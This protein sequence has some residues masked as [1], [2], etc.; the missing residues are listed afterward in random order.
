MNVVKLINRQAQVR[1]DA[2]A[3]MR[4]SRIIRYRQLAAAINNLATH[5]SAQGI[6]PGDRVGVAMGHMPVHMVFILA[7][8]RLRAVSLPVHALHSAETR[9]AIVDHFKPVTI[10]AGR[11]QDRVEGC[12]L[13]LADPSWMRK[14]A[15]AKL[16]P[17][18][19]DISSKDWHFHLSSGS[20]GLPKGVLRT[21]N[22]A[23]S[24]IL[25]QAS[26]VPSDASTRFLCVMDINTGASLMRA[27][28]YLTRGSA[29]IFPEAN[30]WEPVQ[31]I[32]AD[33]E[34][35][36]TFISPGHLSRW[37]RD[38]G[39]RRAPSPNLTYVV[40]GGG[41]LSNA[42]QQRATQQITSKI[43]TCYGSTETGLMA[44]QHPDDPE[45]E[46][47]SLGRVVPW[48]EVQVVDSG[49]QPL[50]P[51]EQGR[52]RFR[53]YGFATSY[54]ENPEA[55]ARFFRNSWFYPGDIG[56]VSARGSLFVESR[57]DDMLNVRGL[58][59]TPGESEGVLAAHPAV[60]EAATFRAR[61]AAG[62]EFLV[63]AVV[64]RE[65]IDDKELLKYCKEKLGPR[66]PHRVV[67]VRELPRDAMGKVLRS[68]LGSKIKPRKAQ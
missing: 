4:G 13:L 2:I 27:L 22:D 51:G 6:A 33:K 47:E 17:T 34:P 15:E 59:V 14:P 9:K 1:P 58:K 35:T 63:A 7:L 18:D 30:G 61:N 60:A 8:A 50:A 44:L 45:H 42:L 49:D 20:T 29:V 37:L 36:H 52:L 40:I 19:E 26:V 68:E 39:E 28:R 32:L 46:S 55:T 57:E 3:L 48:A 43:F 11:E 5:L 38:L 23:L 16:P 66:S 62:E 12:S 10:V 25:F 21:H 41:R 65:E 64:K 24:Q 54:Y 53:G 56:R 31:A 67:S